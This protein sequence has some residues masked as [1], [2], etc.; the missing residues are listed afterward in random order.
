MENVLKCDALIIDLKE[1]DKVKVIDSAREILEID[2]DTLRTTRVKKVLY[3]ITHDL[4][5]YQIYVLVKNEFGT[6]VP[7]SVDVLDPRRILLKLDCD[8]DFEV[9][10]LY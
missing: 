9:V 4:D 2:V 6:F 10:I 8:G 5:T 7:F 1:S 3:E